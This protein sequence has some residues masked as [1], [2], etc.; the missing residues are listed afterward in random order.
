LRGLQDTCLKTNE[1]VYCTDTTGTMIILVVSLLSL[2]QVLS[3]RTAG[4]RV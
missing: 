4:R 2:C 3:L 1:T